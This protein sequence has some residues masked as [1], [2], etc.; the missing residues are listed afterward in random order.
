MIKIWYAVMHDAE[1]TDHGYGS[2]RKVEALR[3]A[4]ELRK[5]GH[6]DAYVVIVDAADDHALDIIADI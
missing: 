1:D 3:M 6:P 5:A 4:R 2:T